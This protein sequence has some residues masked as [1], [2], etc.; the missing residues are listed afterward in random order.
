[1]T[2]SSP[3]STTVVSESN[4]HTVTSTFGPSGFRTV[5]KPE[6]EALRRSGGQGNCEPGNGVY[7]CSPVSASRNVTKYSKSRVKDVRQCPP[8]GGDSGAVLV[9]QFTA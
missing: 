4:I 3:H 2:F 9:S 7:M 5:T 8:I 1:M 6:M